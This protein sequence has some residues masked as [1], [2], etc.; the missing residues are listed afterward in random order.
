MEIT[1]HYPGITHEPTNDDLRDR[2][3]SERNRLLAESDWTQLPDAKVDKEAWAIYRQQLR[4]ATKNWEPS[5]IWVAPS[6]PF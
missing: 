4:D 5:F 3:R 1:L 6:K 2:M